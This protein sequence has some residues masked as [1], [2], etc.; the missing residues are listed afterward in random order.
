MKLNRAIVPRRWQVEA[1][2]VWEREKRG[3]V[4]VV[5]GG[6]KT[7]FAYLCLER[8]F[9]EHTDGRALI[10]VP[11]IALLDQWF[12]DICDATDLDESD[13]GCYSGNQR[14][15]CPARIN[16]LVLNTARRVCH[17]L[18]QCGST[19]L[20]VDECHRA[21]AAENSRAL[22]GVHEA[23]LGLSATPERESDNGF[24]SRIVPALGPIIYSYDY[25]QA[26]A[27]DII[28]DFNLINVETTLD[29]EDVN[30]MSTLSNMANSISRKQIDISKAQ[31]TSGALSKKMTRSAQNAIR[32]PWA[33]KLALQHQTERVII[34]HERVVAL[35]RIGRLIS[36]CGQNF[37]AYHSQMS[38]SHRRDNLRLFRR[39]MINMLVTCRALDEGANIPEANI[40]IVAHSTSSTRQRIQRLGRILRPSARKEHATV[41]TLYT[42]KDQ[43]EKLKEEAANMEGVADVVWMRGFVG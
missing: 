28:V 2:E 26:K 35:G 43:Q 41:Y 30:R 39:G 16:I 22:Q 14:P 7:V 36:Q 1:A 21:G 8:F 33:V 27:D 12:I 38:E 9:A 34:F 13:V 31:E 23:T 19:I 11:T 17:E 37:V 40:A 6:G 29:H 10:V 32:I 4:R 25:L 20:I 18:S 15:E 24:E 42:T 3:I 5:T